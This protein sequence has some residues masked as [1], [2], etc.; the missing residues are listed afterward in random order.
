MHIGMIGGIGPAATEFYY[1]N[2]VKAFAAVHEKMELTIVH[3]EADELVSNVVAN[4]P[5]KQA[6]LFLRLALR[7]EAAGADV[8]VISSIAGHFCIPQ[9]E[10]L[11]PLPIVSA[12]P[13]LESEIAKRR[14]L[15]IG[16]I[17]NRVSMESRLFGGISSVDVVVPSGDNLDVVHNEYTKMAITGTVDARQR[18]LLFSIGKELCEKQ[19][20][21][22]VV[23]AGTDLFLAFNG[24]ECG[25]DVIDSALVHID[26][27][28]RMAIESPTS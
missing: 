6:E 25:F 5:Q 18:E 19:G 9:F 3:A 7:L 2:L 22:A 27:L 23:L 20:A 15:K 17:G 13:A 26:A 11:S 12:I 10:K 4:A 21:E 28:C 16:L 8:I 14:L 1:R 24:A